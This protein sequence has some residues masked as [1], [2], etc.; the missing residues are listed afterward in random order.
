[1]RVSYLP[2]VADYLADLIYTLYKE[3]YFSFEENAFAYVRRLRGEI[4]KYL[5]DMPPKRAPRY[6]ERYGSDLYY[7]VF[8]TSKRTSWYI[9]YSIYLVGEQPHYLV[10]HI[11][12]NHVAGQYFHD[13][14]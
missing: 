3:N 8:R 11:S 9:F 6:F 12:N 10:R 4:D 5:P 1:M 7:A 13:E 14:E 2:E